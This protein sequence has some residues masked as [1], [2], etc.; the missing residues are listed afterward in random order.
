MRRES[1]LGSVV[2]LYGRGASALLAYRGIQL[3]NSLAVS[4]L[5]ARHYGLDMI[6][7]FA[8]GFI[9]VLFVNILSPLGLQSQLA[10]VRQPHARLCTAGLVLQV[11]QWPIVI[12][13]LYGYARWQAQS[14]SEARIIFLV[15]LNGPLLALLNVGI[16]LSVLVNRESDALIVG[17]AE[18]LG[19]IGAFIFGHDGA[20]VASWLLAGRCLGSQLI[21]SRFEFAWIRW[22]RI[23]FIG[24]RSAAYIVPEVLGLLAEQSGPLLLAQVA[25]RAELGV[26][27]LCQQILN[28]A[29]TPVAA[30]VQARYP[31]L[32]RA[33]DE[34][35]QRLLTGVTQ[36]ALAAG[37]L[38][39]AG[40]LV[41]G[42][43]VYRVPQLIPMMVVLSGSLLWR[44]R[45]YYY[46]QAFRASGAV[47]TTWAVGIFK[48][49]LS[50]PIVLGLI[51]LFHVWGAIWSILILAVIVES[52]YGFV[53][54]RQ[55]RALLVVA[56]V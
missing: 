33:T 42:A 30:F 49:V 22:A 43:T 15:S 5:L 4:I 50:V 25:P 53:S 16:A 47:R 19:T 32:V 41:L 20:S 13:L 9:A 35:R 11:I 39:V 21:W 18:S 14:A 2:A 29:E 10:R 7:T 31:L 27:R 8:I 45:A 28:A 12:L 38:C 24:R 54:R 36:L 37:V 17:A 6:G 46:E 51:V 56:E 26:F 1:M 48:I 40:S 34:M 55:R 23:V 3:V 44:Y 52:A